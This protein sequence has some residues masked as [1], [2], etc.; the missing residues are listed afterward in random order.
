[1]FLCQPVR[2]LNSWRRLS[3]LPF[4]RFI[5]TELNKSYETANQGTEH[6]LA[7]PLRM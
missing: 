7:G 4:T 5:K 3:K 1:M 2:M 6:R